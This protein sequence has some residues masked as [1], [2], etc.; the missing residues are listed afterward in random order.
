MWIFYIDIERFKGYGT[1]YV[2]NT[3]SLILCVGCVLS[4][5]FLYIFTSNSFLVTLYYEFTILVDPFANI[6]VVLYYKIV[7]GERNFL[8]S[9]KKLF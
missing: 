3:S 9:G 6:I 5:V 1:V 4:K 2:K 8:Q 7:F